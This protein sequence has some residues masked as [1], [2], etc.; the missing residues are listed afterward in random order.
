VPT[1]TTD[2]IGSFRRNLGLDSEDF[3]AGAAWTPT[4]VTTTPNDTTAPD[5]TTTADR[6][7]D[8]SGAAVGDIRQSVSGLTDAA[9]HTGSVFIKAGDSAETRIFLQTDG[10]DVNTDVTVTWT[11]GVPVISGT[12]FTGAGVHTSYVRPYYSTLSADWYRVEIQITY[13]DSVGAAPPEGLELIIQPAS[14]AAAS[15]TYIYVWGAQIE[16]WA[17]ASAYQRQGATDDWTGDYATITAW[18][19]ARSDPVGDDAVYI[20]A[21]LD[22]AHVYDA[23]VIEISSADGNTDATRYRELTYSTTRYV[24]HLHTGPKVYVQWVDNT[25]AQEGIRVV[26]D[27]FQMRG[28]GVICEDPRQSEGTGGVT[29]SALQ[30]EGDNFTAYGCF[31]RNAESVKARDP[32]ATYALYCVEVEGPNPGLADNARFFNCIF[33]GGRNGHGAG[34]GILFNNF[35]QNGGVYNCAAYS[36]DGAV[37]SRGFWNLTV[38][39]NE[40]EIVNC[41]AMDCHGT[42]GD[43][44]AGVWSRYGYNI[45]SDDNALTSFG[46]TRYVKDPSTGAETGTATGGTDDFSIPYLAANSQLAR[47]FSQ[48]MRP[49]AQS[50]AYG[51]GRDE[52]GD[53]FSGETAEDYLGTART[54]SSWSIGPFDAAPPSFPTSAVERLE[55]IGT[56]TEGRHY[57]NVTDWL[58]ATEE[59][60]LRNTGEIRIGEMQRDDASDDDIGASV[61]RVSRTITDAGYYR[62]LR[63]SDSWRYNPTEQAG[64]TLRGTATSDEEALVLVGEDH[65]HALGLAIEMDYSGADGRHAARVMSYGVRWDAVSLSYTTGTAA[66]KRSLVIRGSDFRGTNLLSLGSGGGLGTRTGYFIEECERTKLYHCIATGITG[67]ASAVG[68]EDGT[69]AIRTEWSGCIGALCDTDFS[70]TGTLGA[71]VDFSIS[72]D[73]TLDGLPG[74]QASVATVDI[75]ANIIPPA[76]DFRLLAG[77]VALNAGR[78]LSPRFSVDFLG[79]RRL[80]PFDIGIFEG[81]GP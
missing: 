51:A 24:P 71:V 48:D 7:A 44:I 68:F 29:R 37:S 26:E 53:G 77:S 61:Y 3:D 80:A 42:T 6:L 73:A 47:S 46:G 22:G 58:L 13:D 35:S 19:T 27:Y 20:G 72:T 70:A 64:A 10:G 17:T 79:N 41:L 4:N 16:E 52:S 5:G 1:T 78:N 55:L 65:F 39:G 62:H 63:G 81:V 2:T 45:T 50:A 36:C 43:D 11:D 60:S 8:N 15:Q 14:D 34:T 59:V 31:F 38:A 30:V 33:M 9:V 25:A 75:W 32:S 28:V 40:P 23:D 76:E 67:G 74:C 18:E 66:T 54:G 56:A 21:L 12:A 57:A 69:R 49:K